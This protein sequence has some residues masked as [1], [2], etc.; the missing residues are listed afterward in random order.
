MPLLG[1]AFA[2][3]DYGVRLRRE[4]DDAHAILFEEA[5]GV[6]DALLAATSSPSTLSGFAYHIILGWLR[7]ASA[8]TV[9]V[10][11][12]VHAANSLPNLS[13]FSGLLIGYSGSRPPDMLLRETLMY[14]GKVQY[15]RDDLPEVLA[16]LA[17]VHFSRPGMEFDPLDHP[18][19]PN[20]D[21]QMALFLLS[22]ALRYDQS[23]LVETVRHEGIFTV[24]RSA[25]PRDQDL[26][27]FAV[28]HPDRIDEIRGVLEERPGADGKLIV[29]ILNAPARAI[30]SGVL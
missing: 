2:I 22:Y 3:L 28:E 17:A 15:H 21:E 18:D 16:A 12:D 14:H 23:S 13:E 29:S 7:T 26:I 27:R 20:H 4:Q 11:L 24:F 25:V 9:S 19:E 5:K 8:F 10:F 6:L 1:N 30:S